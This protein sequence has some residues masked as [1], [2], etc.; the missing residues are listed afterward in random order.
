MAYALAEFKSAKEKDIKLFL[1]SND[2]AKI[3]LNDEVIYNR[4]LG[5]RAFA[6]NE[7]LDIHVKKGW[8][9]LLVKVENL[10]ASWGLYVRLIDPDAEIE[11]REFK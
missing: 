4:H 7:F 5:R 11:M 9:R 6:D 1:G 2:G 10:G 3:W 8:N